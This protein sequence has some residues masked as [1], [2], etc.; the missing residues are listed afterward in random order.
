MSTNELNTNEMEV[1]SGGVAA[2][3]MKNKPE[4]K[5]G[6]IIHKITDTDTLWALS[7]HYHTTIEAI[8]KANPSIQ[9]RRLIRTGYWLYIPAK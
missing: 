9:D 8:M 2:G 4:P 3:G 1:V 6:Y 5:S 7:R